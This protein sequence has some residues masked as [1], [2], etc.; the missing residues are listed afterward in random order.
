[1]N[2]IALRPYQ[3]RAIERLRAHTRAGARR[4]LIVAPTGAGK[5]TIAASLI[6]D[7]IALGQRVLFVAHRREL[8]TQAYRRLIQ[9]GLPEHTV[10]V[11]MG[12]DARRRPGA[13]VQVASIDTLVK[14]LFLCECLT[15][16]HR[17]PVVHAA[18]A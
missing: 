18:A 4:L 11:I 8:I 15:R 16:E 17:A 2:R 9:M 7:A 12:A 14:S 6:V 13:M 5:T 3:E 1:M 10:G